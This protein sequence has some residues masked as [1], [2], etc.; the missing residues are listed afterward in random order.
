[1]FLSV[2]CDTVSAVNETSGG[3]CVSCLC[4]ASCGRWQAG[5]NVCFVCESGVRPHRVW[6]MKFKLP[7][8]LSVCEVASHSS[9]FK[10]LIHLVH[11]CLLCGVWSQVNKN[12]FKEI[13]DLKSL[14]EM[15]QQ[16]FLSATVKEHFAHK[17]TICITFNIRAKI[18]SIKKKLSLCLHAGDSWYWKH[19]VFRLSHSCQHLFSRT[20]WG[21]SV[22]F[23]TN[24]H[25]KS[26]MKISIWWS[27]VKLTMTS[28]PSHS[29]ESNISKTPWGNFVKFG[30][31]VQLDSKMKWL[32][33]SD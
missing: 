30:K 21:I 27:E 31:N 10:M 13:R 19:N 9:E 16:N 26:R 6:V 32:G 7:V 5:E 25:F 18:I 4:E 29:C 15:N 20:H 33:S 22:K 17:M 2:L 14:Q 23:G 3:S 11:L 12:M 24:I 28:H 1:M 8:Y